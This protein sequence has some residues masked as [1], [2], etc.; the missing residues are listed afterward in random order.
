MRQ[1]YL[2]HASGTKDLGDG[3]VSENTIGRVLLVGIDAAPGMPLCCGTG[4]FSI[5]SWAFRRGTGV[6]GG[7]RLGRKGHGARFRDRPAGNGGCCGG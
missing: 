7:V 3:I 6:G 5:L 1:L 4:L 2:S